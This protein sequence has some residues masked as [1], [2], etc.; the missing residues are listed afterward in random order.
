[1]R[2]EKGQEGKV[3]EVV[4]ATVDIRLNDSCSIVNHPRFNLQMVGHERR[5]LAFEE[6][7]IASNDVLF[8][9]IRLVFLADDCVRSCWTLDDDNQIIDHF[10]KENNLNTTRPRRHPPSITGRSCCYCRALS[11]HKEIRE[12]DREWQVESGVDGMLDG[13][14]VDCVYPNRMW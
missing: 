13:R 7:A 5:Q 12:R 11:R 8:V 10:I 1:M 6:G 4:D 2:V 9:D 14:L 3:E